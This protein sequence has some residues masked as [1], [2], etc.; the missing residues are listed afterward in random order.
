MNIAG[1]ISSS[2]DEAMMDDGPSEGIMGRV[3][4]LSPYMLYCQK[5]G[6]IAQYERAVVGRPDCL[7]KHYCP[8]CQRDIDPDNCN[9]M[10]K[11]IAPQNEKERL[12]REEERKKEHELETEIRKRSG[13]AFLISKQELNDILLG[14]MIYKHNSEKKEAKKNS[15]AK[16][17]FVDSACKEIQRDKVNRERNT[18]LAVSEKAF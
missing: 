7:E 1:S 13:S 12:E 9:S 14:D 3:K 18:A 16:R 5:C 2:G 6:N 15:K 10:R 11:E 17:G 8:S 4:L